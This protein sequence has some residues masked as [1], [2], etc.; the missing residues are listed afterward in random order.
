M[1]FGSIVLTV[2]AI[3]LFDFKI[4]KNYFSLHSQNPIDS[5]CTF[6]V[7]KKQNFVMKAALMWTISDFSTYGMLSEWSTHEK[8]VYPYCMK[9]T[10]LFQ[11]EHGHKP[12]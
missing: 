4:F 9:N 8:L 7:S 2:T 11:L 6:D 12:Y 1:D 10:K 3:D 5:M